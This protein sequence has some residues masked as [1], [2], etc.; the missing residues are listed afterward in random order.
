MSSVVTTL[1]YRSHNAKQ[2]VES[3]TEGFRT[4]GTNTISASANST[5]LS[6]SGNV[7]STMRVGDILLVNNESRL[8]TNIASNGTS[9]TINSTFS[10][11]I[12]DALFKTREPLASFDTYYFL[13]GRSTPW[14]LG[15]S[16]ISTPVDSE[17]STNDYLD[18]ALAIRRITEE[19][20]IFVVPKVDWTANS[21]YS[22]F[23]HRTNIARL[24]GNTSYPFYVRNST[25]DVF[26]CLYNGRTTSN[27]ATIANSTAEPS[28]SGVAS[29]SD[30]ITSAA[31]P[32][33]YY[34]WK[35][36]YTI[37]S[38]DEEKFVTGNYMPVRDASDTLDASTGDVFNDS[39]ARYI[40]FNTA[41]TTGNGGIYQIVVDTAGT[42]YSSAAPPSVV[43][44]GDGTAAVAT[45]EISG[46]SIIDI[47]MVSYG[48][49]YSFADVRIVTAQGGSGSG[50][51]ASAIIS[52]RNS[53]ANTSGLHYFSNHAINN[54]S[55]LHAKNVMLYVE[56]EGSEGGLIVTGNEFRRI[57]IL[58][59][60]LLV[61]GEV[62]TANLYDMTTTLT[63]QSPHTF[64]KDEIVYQASTGAYGVVA[65]QGAGTLKLIH[66][67]RAAFT[68]NDAVDPT[69]I[70]IGNGNTAAVELASGNVVPSALPESFV[71]IVAASG[72]TGVV[73]AVSSP[74]IVP[75]TGEILYV[76]HLNPVFRA[77]TQTEVIRTVLTF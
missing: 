44:D 6:I 49:N 54:K 9:V 39:S 51:T 36:L 24:V 30:I 70:G 75:R 57:A 29:P 25:N 13:I 3:L 52:P 34:L 69:I 50:A 23:D 7:F 11:A 76:Q 73:T 15:D 60:P 35:Y 46:G 22:M 71:N 38:E 31:G 33:R 43:I 68:A 59:N 77:N 56:L 45:V 1:K 41:R 61:N 66:V 74:Y 42:G 58:K 62:A 18:D 53:F 27:D 55:E 40:T 63:I 28:I 20:L 16:T 21:K 72:A 47:H 4:Y 64:K 17:E 48:E 37:S 26:K 14:P 19:D 65:E 10:T 8:I 12:S 67:S 5:V 32:N 2:F